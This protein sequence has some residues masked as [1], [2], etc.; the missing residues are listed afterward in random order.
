MKAVESMDIYSYGVKRGDI[1]R[2]NFCRISIISWILLSITGWISLKWLNDSNYW[3]IWTIYVERNFENY[4]Y[5]PFQMHVALL[6]ITFIFSLILILFGFIIFFIRTTLQKDKQIINGLLGKTSKYHFIPLF[7]ASA[8]F[9][10][11][12]SY[13][14]KIDFQKKSKVLVNTGFIISLFGLISMSFIYIKTDLNNC[15]LYEILFIKKG[16][17]SCLIILMWYYFCYNIYYVR[18]ADKPNDS[19]KDVMN[20]KRGCGL[21]C[22]IAFGIG[23]LIFSLIFKDLI[24]CFMNILIY[25]GLMVYYLKIPDY[26]R[27]LKYLN[28]N[29]DLIVDIII[30][31][32][33]FITFC[34]LLIK[35][36][37]EC[38]K[39]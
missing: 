39:S 2:K 6:Y 9:I 23:S 3:I 34:I 20:W 19:Y 27:K 29:G 38:F 15:K 16:S 1:C 17:Y 7:L 24:V 5:M 4:Y 32:F 13:K 14:N 35:Y 31:F 18:R 33:S 30:L 22:S 11:G 10:I 8:L 25:I 21:F 12:L 37:V 26:F 28:K 36:R